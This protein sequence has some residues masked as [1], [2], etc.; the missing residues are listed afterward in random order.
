MVNGGKL[1]CMYCF[2]VR[3]GKVWQMDQ[4]AV[5]ILIIKMGLWRTAI[6]DD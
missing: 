4:F 1:W 2:V 3:Q 5:I 6:T